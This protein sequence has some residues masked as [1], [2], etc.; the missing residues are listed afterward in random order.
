MDLHLHGYDVAA[1]GT[2][3]ATAAQKQDCTLDNPAVCD[4]PGLIALGDDLYDT[5]RYREAVGIFRQALALE[6]TLGDGDTLDIATILV[7]LGAA[8]FH[9]T[10]STAAEPI[11]ARA[12]GIRMEILGDHPDTAEVLDLISLV[13]FA[14][15]EAV[16]AEGLMGDAARM[17]ARIAAN[18]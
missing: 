18:P 1:A 10:H 15:A 17:R 6:D 12:L 3:H 2:A 13:R 14:N 9:D 4:G 5:G 11:L 16:S 7:R 8:M